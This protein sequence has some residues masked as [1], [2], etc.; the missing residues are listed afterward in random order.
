MHNQVI[1]LLLSLILV[2]CGAANND[3][4]DNNNP[5]TQEGLRCTAIPNVVNQ[6]G[7]PITRYLYSDEMQNTQIMAVTVTPFK[8]GFKVLFMPLA[9][10][11]RYV[12]F[13]SDYVIQD[14]KKLW[15][16]AIAEN[17]ALFNVKN[18]DTGYVSMFGGDDKLEAGGNI[19][20]K[21]EWVMIAQ[22][23]KYNPDKPYTVSI[24]AG[25]KRLNFD[26]TN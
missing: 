10:G 16:Y 25:Y 6:N 23:L 9:K 1:T 14:G 24:S 5:L 4:N 15:F 20:S 22:C 21:T 11:E 2:A 3:T 8:T 18:A 13:A 17:Q 7:S 26:I 19:I 12:S